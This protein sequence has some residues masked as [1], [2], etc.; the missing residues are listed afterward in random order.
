MR[1]IATN[2]LSHK[3]FRRYDDIPSHSVRF[4]GG[5]KIGH[6]DLTARARRSPGR[7][8]YSC[9]PKGRALGIVRFGL[10]RT[11]G[12]PW[13][14]PIPAKKF[15]SVVRLHNF[16][17]RVRRV[18]WSQFSQTKVLGEELILR[19]SRFDWCGALFVVIGNVMYSGADG[20]A[21]HQASIVGP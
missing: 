20:I 3:A 10:T 19:L 7:V 5:H 8:L 9:A 18:E 16:Y 14:L 11:H 4:G 2:A 21:A 1:P 6:S 15:S 17:P 12:H 13:Y